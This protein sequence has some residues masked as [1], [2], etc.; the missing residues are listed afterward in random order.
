[1]TSF[2]DFLLWE[3]ASSD[4]IDFKKVYVDIAGD[5]NAGLMLSE[6]VYWYLPGKNG[7]PNKLKVE[8]DGYQWIAARRG[9][10]WDRTRLTPDQSDRA[11]AIL[12]QCGYLEK[13]RYKFAGEV[14]VHIRLIEDKF[15][16]AWQYFIHNPPINQYLPNEME[17]PKKAKSKSVKRQNPIAEK[18]QIH[19]QRVQAENTTETTTD[20]G[21]VFKAYE[22]EIG[23]ISPHIADELKDLAKD[24]P[25]D[26][27]CD[28]IR[29]A[30]VSNAKNLRYIRGILKN[31]KAEGRKAKQDT[32]T[33]KTPRAA[34]PS[35]LPDDVLPVLFQRE[36]EAA[37]RTS[38]NGGHD[39]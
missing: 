24:T 38:Q 11:M 9:E 28:A 39:E 21:V 33:P 37:E 5:L 31:W 16:E 32:G 2:K 15:L 4:T 18:S 27:L 14:T 22:N 30:A 12:C 8:R 36:K 19:I 1:M 13:K 25:I 6:I 26:W 7:N 20:I 10:W 29:E 34:L 35:T 17:L 3:L 23:T